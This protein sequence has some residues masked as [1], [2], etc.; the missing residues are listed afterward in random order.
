MRVSS[1]VF[2]F[3]F[4]FLIFCFFFFSVSLSA[5]FFFS[6]ALRVGC[7]KSLLLQGSQTDPP[8]SLIFQDLKFVV[9]S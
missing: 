9:G 6:S 3:C 8:I 7:W 1:T 2:L 4:I 5:H